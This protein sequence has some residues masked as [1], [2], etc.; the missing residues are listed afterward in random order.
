MPKETLQNFFVL[1][2]FWLSRYILEEIHT[3]FTGKGSSAMVKIMVVRLKL[4]A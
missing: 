1:G 4:G 2:D 3:G